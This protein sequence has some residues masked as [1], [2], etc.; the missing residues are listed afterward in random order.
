MAMDIPNFMKKDGGKAKPK[1]ATEL[2]PMKNER[3]VEEPEDD[4]VEELY[5]EVEDVAVT[6]AVAEDIFEGGSFMNPPTETVNTSAALTQVKNLVKHMDSEEK[7]AVAEALSVEICFNRIGKELQK[8][9][10]FAKAIKN[11]FDILED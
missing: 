5:E 11:A 4:G 1:F 3:F 2:Q 9:K 8:N 6:T 7:E 10:A